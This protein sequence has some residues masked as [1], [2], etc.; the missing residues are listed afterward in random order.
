MLLASADDLINEQSK[1]IFTLA[2]QTSID[3]KVIEEVEHEKDRDDIIDNEVSMQ[4]FTHDIISTNGEVYYDTIA[5]N[6][7]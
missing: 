7:E 6:H 4:C 1:S 3:E 5:D 2:S